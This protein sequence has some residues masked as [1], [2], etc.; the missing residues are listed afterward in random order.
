[1]YLCIKVFIFFK[2][3]LVITT[4]GQSDNNKKNSKIFTRESNLFLHRMAIA[5]H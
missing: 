5:K 1:M 4:K 2:V 3:I